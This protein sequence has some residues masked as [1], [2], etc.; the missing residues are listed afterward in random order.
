MAVANSPPA[1]IPTASETIQ[2]S[3]GESPGSACVADQPAYD[4]TVKNA[5]CA[6]LST[7]IRPQISDSPAAIR[8]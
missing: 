6:K 8:K 1:T 5:P 2:R 4:A 7:R 3:V